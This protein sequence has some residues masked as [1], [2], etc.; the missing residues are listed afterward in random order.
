MEIRF[1]PGDEA[2]FPMIYHQHIFKALKNFKS[3]FDKQ[4]ALIRGDAKKDGAAFVL[5]RSAA[6]DNIKTSGWKPT[7]TSSGEDIA[8][9][10]IGQPEVVI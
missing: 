9:K 7:K 1:L 3:A 4:Y 8:T 6:A 5:K 2:A 10:T